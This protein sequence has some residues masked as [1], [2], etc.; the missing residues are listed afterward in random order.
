MQRFSY[1]DEQKSKAS[2]VA[3]FRAPLFCDWPR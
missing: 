2:R 1:R 3:K